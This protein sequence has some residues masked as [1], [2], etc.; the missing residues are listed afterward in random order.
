[1][2]P[3]ASSRELRQMRGVTTSQASLLSSSSSFAAGARAAY[4]IAAQDLAVQL[5]RRAVRR[6]KMRQRMSDL[7]DASRRRAVQRKELVPLR[8][9]RAM[10]RADELE[11]ASAQAANEPIVFMPR[12]PAVAQVAHRSWASEQVDEDD[13][14]HDESKRLVRELSDD[15]STMST[16]VN[17]WKQPSAEREWISALKGNTADSRGFA[18]QSRMFREVTLETARGRGVM[19]AES[20]ARSMS[21]LCFA[22]PP[23]PAAAHA[24]SDSD[25]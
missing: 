11:R 25:D 17:R 19:S 9:E 2:S 23:A 14:E 24:D 7:R 18:P 16:I 3:V 15:L 4:E 10:Q 5:S 22:T 12:L 1:M 20:V 8:R 13:V 21:Q 6:E